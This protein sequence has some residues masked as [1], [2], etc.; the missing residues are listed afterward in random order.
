MI[1]FLHRSA[2]PLALVMTLLTSE[3]PGQDLGVYRP[4]QSFS[5]PVA[6][7]PG[8]AFFAPT[9]KSVVAVDFLSSSESKRLLFRYELPRRTGPPLGSG[10]RV[11]GFQQ[12]AVTDVDET[13]LNLL[14]EWIRLAWEETQAR[15]LDDPR[16]LDFEYLMEKSDWQPVCCIVNKDFRLSEHPLFLRYNERW[17]AQPEKSVERERAFWPGNKDMLGFGLYSPF[18]HNSEA[19]AE[20]WRNAARV[21][22]LAA[23]VPESVTCEA[24]DGPYAITQ[25]LE[26]KFDELAFV[27]LPG[28]FDFQRLPNILDSTL[29]VLRNGELSRH[30]WVWED[31]EKVLLKERVFDLR[32]ADMHGIDVESDDGR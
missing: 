4:P 32:G 17:F 27:A 29:I 31:G 7:V 30:R 14:Q 26:V 19:I 16:K 1:V 20:D 6:F 11:Y 9:V 5:R 8:D 2:L 24:I 21:K 13:R 22:P 3:S 18:I 15:R 28:E 10:N 12:L 25:P 23:K